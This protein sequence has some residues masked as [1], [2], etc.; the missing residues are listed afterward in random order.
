MDLDQIRLVQRSFARVAADP[1]AVA[2][3]FYARLFELDVSTRPLFTSDL[4]AQGAKL[5]TMLALVVNGLDHL[6]ALIPAVE[7]LARR[8]VGYGVVDRHYASVGAALLRT[9]EQ[10]LGDDFT[11]DVRAAWIEAYSILSTTMMSAA[12]AAEA[13]APGEIPDLSRLVAI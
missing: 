7:A 11:P 9:L 3:T 12:R 4:A 2:R 13:S 8:H 10:A 5:T 1:P 6:E